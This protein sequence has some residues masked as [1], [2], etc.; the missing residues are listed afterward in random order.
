MG[1][2]RDQ[3]RPPRTAWQ[4][5]ASPLLYCRSPGEPSAPWH[6]WAAFLPPS[7]IILGRARMG[8]QVVSRCGRHAHGRV[9]EL[10]SSSR[11]Q[12]SAGSA[13]HQP[14]PPQ[15]ALLPDA[16]PHRD[17]CPLQSCACG[18]TDTTHIQGGSALT[19]KPG[20]GQR[21]HSLLTHTR[22]HKE[23]AC[24]GWPPPL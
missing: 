7:L 15:R 23:Q 3:P 24:E 1:G 20:K 2:G 8:W 5:H 19:L 4:L 11:A 9:P 16:H 18:P 14:V 12:P 10:R 21:G 6:W 22:A 13:G 17:G